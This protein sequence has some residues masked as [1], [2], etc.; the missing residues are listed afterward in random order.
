[1][2][3]VLALLH[4]HGVVAEKRRLAP[5][6]KLMLETVLPRATSA[7]V[8]AAGVSED[9]EL[10]GVGVSPAA[11]GEYSAAKLPLIP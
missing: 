11:F 10:L 5:V 3:S 4:P 8:A 7:T 1:M 6:A 9:V 2:G